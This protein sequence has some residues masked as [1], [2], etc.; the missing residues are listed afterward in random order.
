MS[1]NIYEKRNGFVTSSY[2]KFLRS[3]KEN[4]LSLNTR[5]SYYKYIFSV[6]MLDD[7]DMRTNLR[8]SIIFYLENFIISKI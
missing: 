2:C 7:N 4:K 5:A 3:T 6:N 1:M 8:K